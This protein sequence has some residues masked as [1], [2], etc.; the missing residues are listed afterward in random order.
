[1]LLRALQLAQ[2]REREVHA[3]TLPLSSQAPAR[4]QEAR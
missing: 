4:M 3:R 2:L 1:L